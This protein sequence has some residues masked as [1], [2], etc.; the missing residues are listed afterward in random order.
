[1]P[2][3]SAGGSIRSVC[4]RMLLGLQEFRSHPRARPRA[5]PLWLRHWDVREW[6]LCARRLQGP[7]RLRIEPLYIFVG[8]S[9]SG[10]LGYASWSS[11]AAA[12]SWS[13]HRLRGKRPPGVEGQAVARS[14]SRLCNCAAVQEG[15]K[16]LRELLRPGSSH[17]LRP[18]DVAETVLSKAPQQG[19]HPDPRH[20]CGQQPARISARTISDGTAVRR[21]LVSCAVLPEARRR[22]RRG[23]LHGRGGIQFTEVR[24][25]GAPWEGRKGTKPKQQREPL[26]ICLFHTR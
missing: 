11:M 18:R 1:M 16:A 9:C 2:I 6:P 13:L 24:Q 3:S 15:A 21:E 10:A 4:P 19:A 17:L 14:I 25:P 23:S 8:T 20:L 12:S 7:H 22:W 26:I 5:F